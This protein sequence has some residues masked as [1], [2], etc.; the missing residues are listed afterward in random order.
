MTS[1][2]TISIAALSSLALACLVFGS[3]RPEASEQAK[4][5]LAGATGG[6]GGPTTGKEP[7]DSESASPQDDSARIPPM[8]P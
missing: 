5:I 3:S 8:N 6:E 4:V 1:R 2:W 7:G